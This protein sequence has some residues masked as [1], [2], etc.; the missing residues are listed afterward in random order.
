VEV[1]QEM[2]GIVRRVQMEDLFVDMDWLV[3]Q[4]R[5]KTVLTEDLKVCRVAIVVFDVEGFAKEDNAL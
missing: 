4:T 2:F 1:A 5:Q 3:E